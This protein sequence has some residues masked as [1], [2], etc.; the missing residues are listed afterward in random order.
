MAI[1]T[2]RALCEVEDIS[3]NGDDLKLLPLLDKLNYI[4]NENRCQLQVVRSALVE[5]W[6]KMVDI[7]WGYRYNLRYMQ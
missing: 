7:A 6:G 2:D 4:A 5:E 3:E 1:W